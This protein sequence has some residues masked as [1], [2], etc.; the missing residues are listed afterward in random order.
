LLDFVDWNVLSLRWGGD[1]SYINSYRLVN[2][3]AVYSLVESGDYMYNI[4][5]ITI[6]KNS[7]VTDTINKMLKSIKFFD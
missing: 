3:T 1:P 7:N 6:V 5:I 2:E 4:S